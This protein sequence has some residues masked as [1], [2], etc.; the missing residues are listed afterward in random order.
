MVAAVRLRLAGLFQND[1][2]ISRRSIVN[3]LHMTPPLLQP[4]C[5]NSLKAARLELSRVPAV[6]LRAK[7]E[8]AINQHQNRRRPPGS[9]QQRLVAMANLALRKAADCPDGP[10]RDALLR[11][12]EQVRRSAAIDEWIASP[13]APPPE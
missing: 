12:A 3:W 13:G 6:G 5:N 2:E 1:V 4:Q 10:E 7:M 8:K 11:K 9:L